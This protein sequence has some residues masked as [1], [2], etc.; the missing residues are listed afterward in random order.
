[1][2]LG[3]SEKRVEVVLSAYGADFEGAYKRYRVADYHVNFL[4]NDTL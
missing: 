1:M 3:L 2:K 4:N